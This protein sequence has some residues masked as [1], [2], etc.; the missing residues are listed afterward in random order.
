MHI[1]T[2]GMPRPQLYHIL[3]QTVI[4]RP[5]AWA[6]TDNGAGEGLARYNLAPFS[7][8]NAM[9]ADPPTLA[10]AISRKEDGSKKDT[11]VN[12][13]NQRFCTVHI[14]A[15]SQHDPLVDSSAELPHG[16]SELLRHPYQLVHEAYHPTPRLADAPV[17]F[18]CT[19]D[20]MHPIGKGTTAVAFCTINH[21]FIN[22][23]VTKTRPDGRLVISPQAINPLMRLGGRDYAALGDVFQLD[24]PEK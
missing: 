22:D 15:L 11:W 24:R 2:E 19:L 23:A 12:L 16:T 14:A 17:A 7:F 21:I 10:F 8:F 3:T 13:E 20:H 4:P 6:L 9:A 1:V 5:I 18:F